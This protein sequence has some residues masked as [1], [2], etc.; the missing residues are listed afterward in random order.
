MGWKGVGLQRVNEGYMCQNGRVL[1]FCNRQNYDSLTSMMQY[2]KR[3]RKCALLHRKFMFAKRVL[4]TKT[5]TMHTFK[6]IKVKCLF[7]ARG[8]VKGFVIFFLSF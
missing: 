8:C 3:K 2:E 5:F 1:E 7:G 4:Q 6:Q